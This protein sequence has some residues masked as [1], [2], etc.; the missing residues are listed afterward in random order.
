VRVNA[1]RILAIGLLFVFAHTVRA[2]AL[3]ES[4]V[5]APLRTWIPWA[6]HDADDRACPYLYA[7]GAGKQCV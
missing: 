1:R 5:P 2:E 3:R 6:L 4:E 7:S